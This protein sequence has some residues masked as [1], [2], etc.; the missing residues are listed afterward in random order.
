MSAQTRHVPLFHAGAPLDLTTGS[1]LAALTSLTK[2]QCLWLSLS[3]KGQPDAGWGWL[4]AL[5]RLTS[6]HLSDHE[7]IGARQSSSAW[8][9]VVAA[10]AM[11]QTAIALRNGHRLMGYLL[12]IGSEHLIFDFQA[13][14]HMTTLREAIIGCTV[15]IASHQPVSSH[16]HM[17]HA[18]SFDALC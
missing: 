8:I 18:W 4:Q 13:L 14:G 16:Q 12:C 15:T 1:T 9:V 2:L 17:F 5:H 3:I 11:Y 6:I 7:S 10:I